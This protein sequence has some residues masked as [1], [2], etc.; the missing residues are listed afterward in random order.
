MTLRRDALTISPCT[1][2]DKC[3]GKG[4][5][6]GATIGCKPL[7]AQNQT[8]GNCGTRTRT[9]SSTCTW[10]GWS[11]CTG[12]GICQTKSQQVKV[13]ASCGSQTRTCDSSCQWG[14]WS[15]CSSTG[16]CKPSQ[17]G[18]QTCGKCGVQTRTCSSACTWSAWT[19][20]L[21][22][23]TCSPNQGQ[24][25]TCGNCG[26][27]NRSCN[28]SCK[29]GS[30]GSCISEGA[31][32]LGTK[33]SQTCGKCGTRSRACDTT[34][35]W[36]AWTTCS[37]ETGT[38]T[39]GTT[40]SCTGTNACGASGG[41]T[42]TCSTGCAWGSCVVPKPAKC[43]LTLYA[44]ID[45]YI[46]KHKPYN[47]YGLTY[48]LLSYPHSSHETRVYAK[49]TTPPISLKGK[50]ILKAQA[51]FRSYNNFGL[52]VCANA[53]LKAT[54][55][56]PGAAWGETTLTWNNRPS[57][58]TCTGSTTALTQQKGAVWTQSSS[59][60][61][62]VFNIADRLQCWLGG[63]SNHGLVVGNHTLTTGYSTPE[64]HWY[65]KGS[66]SSQKPRIYIEYQP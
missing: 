8:C 64:A 27:Q 28:S 3:D 25:Q 37:G 61:W 22:E 34:C 29:W 20:C 7:T 35:A 32:K 55:S 46:Y 58:G 51:M 47:N 38:C 5:C 30:W 50:T 19:P 43:A 14:S 13:C 36:G 31:C 49:F 4:T 18:A 66:S 65:T 48:Y 39:P 33:Q 6:K 42:K 17:I 59:Q 57:D 44:L 2:G 45:A 24:S 15:A 12:Q 9:C 62:C 16:I 41:G 23:G 54:G 56:L 26:V 1:A 10:G 21:G 40:S 63:T 52:S 11:A 60:R 53:A